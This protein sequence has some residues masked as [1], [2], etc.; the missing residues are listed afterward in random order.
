MI[1]VEAGSFYAPEELE[2]FRKIQ[3]EI[4]RE[5]Q[6]EIDRQQR[7]LLIKRILFF[8]G[9]SILMFVGYIAANYLTPQK[10]TI[11]KCQCTSSPQ[12]PPQK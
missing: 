8:A 4:Q 3:E 10:E 12:A 6:K 1:E 9:L 11:C 7:S 2:H 5:Q